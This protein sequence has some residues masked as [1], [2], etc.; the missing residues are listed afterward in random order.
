MKKYNVA[1]REVHISHREVEVPDD[2]SR[3]EILKAAEDFE[4]DYL[5]Y[6]HT[7]DSE[8]TTIEE[9]PLSNA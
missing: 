9:I 4:D 7:L 6:S 1:V 8:Y 5:E 2:A 3:E